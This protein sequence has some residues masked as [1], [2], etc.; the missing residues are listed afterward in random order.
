M[1]EGEFESFGEGSATEI[2]RAGRDVEEFD[3]LAAFL[4]DGWMVVEFGDDE[5]GRV[6]G[7]AHDEACFG[8]SG[9]F[10]GVEGACLDG[11][12]LGEVDWSC[13]SGSEGIVGPGF[14]RIGAVGG[15]VNRARSGGK[16]E[17]KPGCDFTAVL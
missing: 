15:V 11:E 7:S 6:S 3:K 1:W 4:F 2:D 9:P 8:E 5:V 17:I 13:V 16:G 12:R 14:A 10:S